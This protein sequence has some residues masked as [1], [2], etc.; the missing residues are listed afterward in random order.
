MYFENCPRDKE[1]TNL[2]NINLHETT[3]VHKKGTKLTGKHKKHQCKQH[4]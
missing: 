1:Q 3:A 2:D 4:H